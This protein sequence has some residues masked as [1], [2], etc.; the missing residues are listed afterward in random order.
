VKDLS[1]IVG[2][3]IRM[4]ELT[5]A[6]GRAQLER[7]GELIGRVEKICLRLT[8]G[9]SDL[10]GFVPP[11]VRRGCR[12]NYYM[13]SAKIDPDAVG[14][15]RATFSRALTAEGFPNAEGYVLPIYQIPMFQQ[16]IAIGRDGFPFSLRPRTYPAGLCP[17]TEAMYESHLLQFQPV[18]WEADDEQV[19]MLINSVRKVYAQAPEL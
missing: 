9:L 15:S 2:F 10:P 19:D 5:A 4:T 11:S 6:V 12:H 7:I 18:S 17:V 16:R 1:N 14:C 3:N 8:A 13:W